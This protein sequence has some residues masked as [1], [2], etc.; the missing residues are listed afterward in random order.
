VTGEAKLEDGVPQG[1]GWFVV[2]ARD[3]RWWHNELGAYCPFESREARFAQLGVNISILPP[4][5]PMAMYHEEEGEEAFLVLCGEC[6]LIVEGEERRL[7]EWD[8]F[9]CPPWTKHVLV[10]EGTEPALVVAAGARGKAGLNYPVDDVARRH[11][12]DVE[13]ETSDGRQAYARFSEPQPG[14]P[15]A[16]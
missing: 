6:T 12:A 16:L 11:G 8:F 9:Y 7:R 2:N 4:G 15:P 14:P 5:K 3:A 13:E 10:G 1:E